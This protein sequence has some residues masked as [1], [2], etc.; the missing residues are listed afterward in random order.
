MA[1]APDELTAIGLRYRCNI[2]GQKVSIV[3]VI[4]NKSQLANKMRLE[5]REYRRE[6]QIPVEKIEWQYMPIDEM[7]KRKDNEFETEDST[8]LLQV[9]HCRQ[10]EVINK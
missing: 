6:W 3:T 10:I 2:N 4:G 8:I 1:G 7:E 9:S 5:K